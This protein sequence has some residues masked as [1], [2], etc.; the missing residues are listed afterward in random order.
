MDMIGLWIKN[1][2]FFYSIVS[3][4]LSNM[5]VIPAEAEMMISRMT[6]H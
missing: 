4:H 1:F 2:K 5:A 6:R 3:C